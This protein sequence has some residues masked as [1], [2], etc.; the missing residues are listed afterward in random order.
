MGKESQ[1]KKNLK[2]FR[3][4]DHQKKQ[5]RHTFLIDQWFST[6]VATPWGSFVLFLEIA[7]ASNKTIHNNYIYF[8]YFVYGTTVCRS[9]NNSITCKN[10]NQLFHN[11]LSAI[12]TVTKF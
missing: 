5:L 6:W 4:Y 2:P 10:D 7:R 8:L 12:M 3:S 11:F 1:V 9:Q